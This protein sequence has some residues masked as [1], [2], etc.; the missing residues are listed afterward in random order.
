[1]SA[2]PEKTRVL[3]LCTGNSCRSQMAEGF[4]RELGGSHYEVNS[5][6]TNP[7]RINPMAIRVM[8]E[9]GIDISDQYSKPVDQLSEQPFDYV[10]TV[11]DH[12]RE[13][14]PIFPHATTQLHWSFEDPAEATGT[15]EHRLS[16]FRAIRNKIAE[17]VRSLVEAYD[18]ERRSDASAPR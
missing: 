7:T 13:V 18:G 15:E 4:L 2:E 9:A 1:M 5:A 8:A 16:V 17:S 11:C 12:A 3:F 6:G 10:I 14:C